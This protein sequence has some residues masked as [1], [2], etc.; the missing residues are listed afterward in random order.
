MNVFFG[1]PDLMLLFLAQV[2][3]ISLQIIILHR[4]TQRGIGAEQ[5][6]LPSKNAALKMDS[7]KLG[8]KKR[9]K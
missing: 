8:K 2:L 1:R 9:R 3:L 6:M 4:M 7:R 5:I